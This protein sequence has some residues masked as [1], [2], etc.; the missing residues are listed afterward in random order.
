MK[1]YF[2]LTFLELAI[3][4]SLVSYIV[5][6]GQQRE[7]TT[8]NN[9]S[10]KEPTPLVGELASFEELK[11]DLRSLGCNL[12]NVN[13]YSWSH[14]NGFNVKNYTEF[15]RIAYN[16]NIVFFYYREEITENGF[17]TSH[18]FSYVFTI[19]DGVIVYWSTDW[20]TT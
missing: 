3:I 1:K 4:I 8:L 6:A 7:N 19:Y 16:T 5:V 20:V 2:V 14:A 10:L 18:G 9:A 13:E 15:R 12:F 11:N 17:V